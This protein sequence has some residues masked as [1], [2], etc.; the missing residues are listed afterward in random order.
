MKITSR[1][2]QSVGRRYFKAALS[3]GVGGGLSLAL[4]GL[5][6][7]ALARL[8]GPREYGV[9][10]A[11][12]AA[13]NLIAGLFQMGQHSALHKML[14]EHAGNDRAR[15]GAILADITLLTLAAL[16]VVCVVM[17][18]GA[19]WIATT[20]Y[21]DPV[22]A[23]A[24]RISAAMIFSMSIFNLSA[25]VTAGLQDFQ[26]Y[27]G[28]ML[29]RSVAYVS[30]ALTGAATFGLKGAFFGQLLA[31]VIAMVAL[32]HCATRLARRRFPGAIRPDFSR[33]TFGPIAAFMIPAF[34]LT[35]LNLPG[36]WWISALLSRSHGFSEV[37]IF[38]V[39][40]A[41]TQIIWL[42]PVNL[43]V[44]AMTFLSEAYAARDHAMFDR[45]VNE[46][47]RAIWLLTTPLAVGAAL[48]SPVLPKLLFGE[49]YQKAAI[50]SLLLCFAAPSMAIIGL[51]NTA[52][53]AAGRIWHNVVI[54][55]VWSVFFAAGTWMLVP[56]WGAVG[57][58]VAFSFSQLIYLFMLCSYLA[59]F[60]QIDRR[61][62]GVMVS[63]TLIVYVSSALIVLHLT[64]PIF[65]LAGGGVLVGLILAEWRWVCGDEQR[66]AFGEGVAILKLAAARS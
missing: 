3:S 19:D 4:F 64:G 52:V 53:A 61:L 54:T 65:Y 21:H 34:L 32:T 59:R 63:L 1:T 6:P 40:Y 60:L 56:R 37:G 48:L 17:L 57:A 24:L 26:T 13:T 28:G 10:A 49:A 39:A 5:A 43:Y 2:N 55:L 51:I 36:Y 41:L 27:N 29:L 11:A 25:S 66:R 22:I 20:V 15:G 18:A 38:S 33:E 58:A 35:L 50:V 30:L 45:L 47:L 23:S 8:L 44:P 9:Y 46:N 14:P 62:I 7:V 16:V 12:M 42:I 31:F